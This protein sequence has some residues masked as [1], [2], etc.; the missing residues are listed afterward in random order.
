MKVSSINTSQKWITP[1][2]TGYIATA[3]LGLA[4]YSGVTKNKQLRKLHKPLAYLSVILTA[5]HIAITEYQYYL[6]KKQSPTNN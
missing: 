6:Y 3:S 1:K 4:T 2:S 5:I